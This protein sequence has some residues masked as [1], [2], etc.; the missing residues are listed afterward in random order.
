M[1]REWIGFLAAMAW[2]AAGCR[3]EAQCPVPSAELDR[4]A[5]GFHVEFD[6]FDDDASA[7][8]PFPNPLKSVAQPFKSATTGYSPNYGGDIGLLLN[9]LDGFGPYA[10][11]VVS[12]NEVID[13]VFLPDD[14]AES[15]DPESPVFL[16]DLE[17]IRADPTA[18]FEA[19]VQPVT[20]WY[21]GL[22]AGVPV[23]ALIVAPYVPLQP[24]HEYAVVI[25]D[26][27]RTYVDEA[28]TA[29]LA[30][31]IGS[32][33]AFQCVKSANAVDP[34]LEPMREGLA[35]LFE[36]LEGRGIDR[37]E[38]A[39][40]THY[41]TQ[42]VEDELVDIRKQLETKDPPI[43]R[44]DPTRIFRDVGGDDGALSDEAYDYFQALFPDDV[45]VDL[46]DYDFSSIGTIAY[47]F[48]PSRDY[49]H[50][51]FELFITDGVT[52]HVRE[53]RTNELEFMVVLP[54]KDLLRNVVPPYKTIVFQHALTVCK[55]SMVAIANEFAER[56]I[57]LVGIDVVAHGSR[58]DEAEL[59]GRNCTIQGIDFLRL[60]NPLAGR[61]GF[62]Q[63][64][65][66]QF[67]LVQMVKHLDLDIAPED[68]KR[69][70]D[71]DRLAYVSQSLGSL[72]G[73]TFI[74]LEPDVGAAVL[75]VGG[76]G[77][78]SVALSYFGD[79]GG[80]PVG[81]D[82]FADLPTFLLD[83]MLILQNAV[84]RADPIHYA[85]RVATAP[86]TIREFPNP[87]KSVLLQEA[88]GDEV[89]GNYS[90]DSLAREM[91]GEVA[92]PSVFRAVPNVA[93]RLAPFEGN[94]GGGQ[95]TIALTQFSPAEHSFLLTQ[96]DPD[97]FCRG[98]VQAAEFVGSYLETGRARVID[99]YT[100]PE[101]SDCP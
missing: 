48:F 74:A 78:Y 49:R 67:Q 32:S 43:G 62:R 60:D 82:G 56:G 23:D 44:I 90:T 65:A 68:G 29:S 27:L 83:M 8:R 1:R 9:T 19:V 35:A 39:F 84:E 46:A 16:V 54:K 53:Q 101:A 45:D 91:G 6:P 47:G 25:T 26:R 64:V 72:I 21:D 81:P 63:T 73:G 38:V 36:W 11:V 13:P 3:N 18:D 92:G 50:P 97:A 87:P 10:P 30:R 52:G 66:D 59:S 100:A 7:L 94:A 51:E 58:S 61:E 14:P 86:L 42:S 22:Q 85:R 69:D 31:C 24:K 33:E 17:A 98:Q 80:E 12:F 89:V 2:G 70:L 4:C 34:R 76:G 41:V 75:N 37:G 40:A 99:A 15:L 79:Q 77:L 5:S 55:E 57:A 96:D 88:V 93:T 95:A 71:T 28:R 20:A